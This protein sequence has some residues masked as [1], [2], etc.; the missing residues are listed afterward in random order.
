MAR[1]RI[2]RI[3][4]ASAVAAALACAAPL[5]AAS[6]ATAASADDTTDAT[7]PVEM[8]PELHDEI[9]KMVDD[10][11]E[12][13]SIVGMSVAVVTPDPATGGPV[14]TTFASGLPSV[15][16]PTPV[17]AS[18]QFEIGS[19]TKAFTA[20]LFEYMVATGRVHP[21][22]KLQ[23]YA[24]IG[25]TVPVYTDPQTGEVSQITL[26]DL[27][28]HEAGLIDMPKNA[29]VKDNPE[30]TQ[31][32]LWQGLE[33]FGTENH[34][35]LWKPGTNWLYSNM[36]FSLL[37]VVMSDLIQPTDWTTPPAFESSLQ[38]AFLND[39]GMS[40]TMLEQYPGLPTGP[41][42]AT[43]YLPDGTDPGYQLG[44]NGNAPTGGLIS[45]ATDMGVWMAAHL[46]Y[47]A[48]SDPV[49]VRSLARTLDQVGQL[50]EICPK[51]DVSSCHAAPFQTGLVW[52]L[53]AAGADD[54]PVPIASKD[55]GTKGFDSLTS[56]A[57][58]LRAG[59]TSMV[60]VGGKDTDGDTAADLAD[61]N[62]PVLRLLYD[63]RAHVDPDPGHHD[64]RK[65]PELAETG[66]DPAELA[67][68]G[69]A[70]AVLLL[71][72]GVLLARGRRRGTHVSR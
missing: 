5:A 46:G 19:I 22:D 67:I 66:I 44:T 27:A 51:P 70:A 30:Y 24:P 17:D 25:V 48:D 49:G 59:I 20:D 65:R 3:L 13:R 16:S 58:T 40:S 34:G 37:G 64:D 35:L 52:Q 60:N 9:Q 4:I 38:T 63:R 15:G 68:G 57:R 45:D 14:S 33:D 6:P 62:D 8:T 36:G 32:M 47:V 11:R 53:Y 55:G 29:H 61:I 23:D 7:G 43:P 12:K 41:R 28:T 54:M 2:A 18:T 56:L 72:G 10:Y 26:R 71:A 69:G 39:L 31:Q 50:D 42:L 1:P 21:D